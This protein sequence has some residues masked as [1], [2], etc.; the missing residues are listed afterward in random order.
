MKS[1]IIILFSLLS[2]VFMQYSQ[3]QTSSQNYIRTRTMTNES[4]TSFVEQ[5]DYYDGLGR[6]LETVQD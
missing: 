3:A 5:V 1:R 6:L 2:T 4:G